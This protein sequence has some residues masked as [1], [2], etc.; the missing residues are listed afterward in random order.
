MFA[1]LHTSPPRAGW[2]PAPHKHLNLDRGCTSSAPRLSPRGMEGGG[3]GGGGGGAGKTQTPPPLELVDDTLP[4]DD[5]LSITEQGRL[6]QEG[7]SAREREKKAPPS[8]KQKQRKH[9]RSEREYV[10]YSTV[11]DYCG[12]T[13]AAGNSAFPRP[14][15]P[16]R[17]SSSP[18]MIIAQTCC[19]ALIAPLLSAASL[20]VCVVVAGR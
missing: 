19:A 9:E 10:Q 3:G 11:Q 13:A 8:A 15:C 17:P 7:G 6:G 16:R 2:L 14:D 4:S 5:D 18:I 1:A 20:C 12:N